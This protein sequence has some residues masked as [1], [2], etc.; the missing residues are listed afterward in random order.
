MPSDNK[1][2]FCFYS[3]KFPSASNDTKITEKFDTKRKVDGAK[4]REGNALFSQ[5]VHCITAIQ[6]AVDILNGAIIVTVY[7]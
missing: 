5:S 7:N 2:A 6:C 1:L 4:I 3:E